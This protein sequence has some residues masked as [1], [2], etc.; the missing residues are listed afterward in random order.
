M[1]HLFDHLCTKQFTSL[2]LSTD[3]IDNLSL[4]DVSYQ[5]DKKS[6][7]EFTRIITGLEDRR[8]KIEA[9]VSGEADGKDAKGKGGKDAKKKK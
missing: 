1:T 8:K 2:L 7:L 4:Q 6:F 5:D 3:F 9:M